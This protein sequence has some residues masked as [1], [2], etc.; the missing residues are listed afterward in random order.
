[1]LHKQAMKEYLRQMSQIHNCNEVKMRDEAKL[2][3]R[4]LRLS[5]KLAFAKNVTKQ[6]KIVQAT[7]KRADY[8]DFDFRNGKKI[9]QV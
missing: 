9:R 7:Y 6:E 1:M 3:Q 2:F 8:A 5:K 4:Y